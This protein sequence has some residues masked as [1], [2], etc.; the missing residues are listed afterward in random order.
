MKKIER[1]SKI[2]EN[3]SKNTQPQKNTRA[4]KRISYQTEHEK[5]SADARQVISTASKNRFEDLDKP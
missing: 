2:Q 5:N 4:L 1:K 3:G